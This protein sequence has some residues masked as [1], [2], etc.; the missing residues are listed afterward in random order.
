MA[1][2]RSNVGARAEMGDEMYPRFP[3]SQQSWPAPSSPV[4]R[5]T[6]LS[7][8][9]TH[10]SSM[11]STAETAEDKRG[12]LGLNLIC[13]RAEP[14]VEIVFV[15]GLGGG[16]RKTWCKDDDLRL[17]W[18]KEWLQRD[19]EFKNARV[20][21][22]GYD[23]E[24]VTRKGTQLDVHDFGKSLLSALL[25][26]RFIRRGRNVGHIILLGCVCKAE[27]YLLDPHRICST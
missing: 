14:L 23:S 6:T 13:D 5:R 17:Y 24:W 12:K 4:K 19:P 27:L 21:S 18:P 8:I 9:F 20:Y 22:F 3:A 25:G 2:R 7:R 10:R 1:N 26:D 11:T 15:H 16:S